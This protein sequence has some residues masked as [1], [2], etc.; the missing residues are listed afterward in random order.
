L[1][2]SGWVEGEYLVDSYQIPVKPEAPGGGYVIEI[3]MYEEST[4]TRLPAFDIQGQAIG[5]KI[6]LGRVRVLRER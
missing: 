1:P 3:G 2:T 5:D 6:V 4:G